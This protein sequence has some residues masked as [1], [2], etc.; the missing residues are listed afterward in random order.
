MKKFIVTG[1]NG[2]IGSHMCYEL[3]KQFPDCKIIG[4]DIVDKPK[5]HRLYDRFVQMDLC[6]GHWN[7]YDETFDAI[8]SELEII[9]REIKK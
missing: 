3:R 2:Y 4:I 6:D 7:F 8:I 5:L 9:L 1:C